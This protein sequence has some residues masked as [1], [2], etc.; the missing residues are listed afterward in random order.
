MRIQVLLLAEDGTANETT[1]TS[2]IEVG[3]DDLR[4]PER[5]AETVAHRAQEG[6]HRLREHLIPPPAR[7]AVRFVPLADVVPTL[8]LS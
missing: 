3:P 1:V 2:T 4:W 6:T 8:D 5:L 7:S